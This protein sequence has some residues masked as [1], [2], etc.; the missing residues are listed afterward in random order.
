MHSMQSSLRSMNSEEA[1]EE[2]LEEVSTTSS[3]TAPSLQQKLDHQRPMI[4][5]HSRYRVV[6][7][8]NSKSDTSNS[9]GNS[10]CYA[11]KR[12]LHKFYIC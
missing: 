7:M 10:R 5:L 6:G 8:S 3:E 12:T 9:S 4:S 11:S 2:D 1:L